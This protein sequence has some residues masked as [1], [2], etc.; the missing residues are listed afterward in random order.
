MLDC[1]APSKRLLTHRLVEIVRMQVF[2]LSAPARSLLIVLEFQQLYF[3]TYLARA[4]LPISI[5]FPHLV[6]DWSCLNG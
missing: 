5:C 1:L 6:L 3:R 2:Y 4:S